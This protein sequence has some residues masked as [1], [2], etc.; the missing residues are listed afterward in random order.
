MKF[1]HFYSSINNQIFVG[2]FISVKKE[3]FGLIRKNN[4]LKKYL[5]EK[6]I[7]HCLFTVDL[8]KY[9]FNDID[10]TFKISY[11]SKD[12]D[13]LSDKFMDSHNLKDYESVEKAT[14]DNI[15]ILVKKFK[16]ILNFTKNYDFSREVVISDDWEFNPNMLRYSDLLVKIAIINEDNDK[17]INSI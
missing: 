13:L 17:W 15:R 9:N 12:I 16:L 8:V 10:K 2:D 5:K 3:F 7:E 1:N 14:E 11:F 4:S 6:N